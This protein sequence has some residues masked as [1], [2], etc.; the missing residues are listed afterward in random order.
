MSACINAYTARSGGLLESGDVG[1]GGDADVEAGR[2]ATIPVESNN[3][4]HRA[5]GG[6]WWNR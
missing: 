2:R 1:Y 6:V 3:C 5:F 4:G